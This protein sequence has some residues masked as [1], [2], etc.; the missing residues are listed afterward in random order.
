MIWDG[1]TNAAVDL[2]PL[3]QNAAGWHLLDA[4]E[5]NDSGLILGRGLLNG[6]NTTF[7]LTP[8]PEPA[9]LSLTAAAGAALLL[10]RRRPC[11]RR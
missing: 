8:V 2:L 10:R 3:V 11:D 1:E 4:Q 5:I 6:V 7:L 9:A